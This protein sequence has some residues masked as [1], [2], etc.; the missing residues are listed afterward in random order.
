MIQLGN[1]NLGKNV[2]FRL[3][4]KKFTF[5][6]LIWTCFSYNYVGKFP[7]SLG[8]I[9]EQDKAWNINF[10][11]LLANHEQ[12][13][14]LER[15][16]FREKLPDRRPYKEKRNVTDNISAYSHV[17]NIGS[18]YFD[19]YVKNYKNRYMKKKGIS[20]LDCYYEN[21]VFKK[22]CHFDD[23][24]A[25]MKNDRK[26]LKNFLFKKYGL[27]IIL[28][29]LLPAIGFIYPTVFGISENY[30][31]IVG[32]CNDNN[33]NTGNHHTENGNCGY[34]WLHIN[35]VLIEKVGHFNAIFSFIMSIIFL[36]ISI[37]ILVKIIKYEKITAGKYKMSVR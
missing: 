28:F 23:I 1:N 33:H 7:K 36:L 6:F 12:K 18:N 25:N 26:S 32:K 9:Q 22:L 30:P 2:N 17:K 11:R 3:F 14:E 24:T 4:L 34:R 29:V 16:R 20:K 19:I 5:I 15:K 8:N 31:G 27:K 35:N 37:Y 13:R 21:K 10:N